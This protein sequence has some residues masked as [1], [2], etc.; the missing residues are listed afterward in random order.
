MFEVDLPVNVDRKAAVV[1][2]ALGGTPASV[3]LVPVD[4]EHDDLMA[5]LRSAGY[6][7]AARTFFI[8][9]GL[10]QYLTPEAVTATLST[11]SAAPRRAA[12]WCS[13]TSGRTSSTAPTPTA[14]TRC[15]GGSAGSGRC[16][17]SGLVPEQLG[18]WL[19]DLGWR[20]DEQ[21]GPSYF[22]DLYI[23]PTGRALTASPIEWTA[24][25]HR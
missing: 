23:R 7:S 25:A 15:T 22:R 2:R 16:G 13:P 21:A 17:R 11:S 18:E 9:E 8:A 4:F 24:L 10:L 1:Q 6:D 20:L 3:H 14:P 5:A 19:A 12:G